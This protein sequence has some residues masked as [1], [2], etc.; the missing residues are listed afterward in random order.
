M[1]ITNF[2]CKSK[3]LIARFIRITR[4]FPSGFHMQCICILCIFV[5]LPSTHNVNLSWN[6]IYFLCPERSILYKKILSHPPPNFYEKLKLFAFLDAAALFWRISDKFL[7]ISSCKIILLPLSGLMEWKQ[8]RYM[9][10]LFAYF[11]MTKWQII[12]IL[13]NTLKEQFQRQL[14]LVSCIFANMYENF[15]GGNIVCQI[16]WRG[17]AF[18]KIKGWQIWSSAGVRVAITMRCECSPCGVPS[19][20]HP[21]M[22]ILKR[23]WN[24]FVFFFH[25]PSILRIIP[26]VSEM[27]ICDWWWPGCMFLPNPQPLVRVP[28]IPGG[29]RK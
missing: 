6:K 7:S 14:H 19:R 17:N 27:P 20:T 1:S 3:I 28:N 24:K 5:L 29:A 16:E 23:I 25:Y 21:L 26:I 4:I 11:V 10:E 2:F 9:C 13:E 15:L 12:I 18:E 8:G 22:R